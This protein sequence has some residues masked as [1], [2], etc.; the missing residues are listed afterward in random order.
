MKFANTVAALVLFVLLSAAWTS[1]TYGQSQV[2]GYP[3]LFADNRAHQVGDV[4]TIHIIEFATASNSSS[5]TT[6]KKTT[7]S[8]SGSGSGALKF[9][10]L[11]GMEGGT[12]AA[13]KGD[14]KTE[15][16]GVLRAKMSARISGVDDNGN[17]IIEGSREVTVNSDHQVTVLRGTVRPEDITTDN[18]V[19]SYNIADAKI[20]YTGKG[21]VNTGQRPGILTRLI[22]WI[23]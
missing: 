18:I 8:A 15:R 7:T 13:F 6:D 4:V 21:L 16:N 20:S 23:F 2:A 10:P 3:S 5:T 9:I 12:A 1:K 11:F 19:Y 14:A 22:N 17:F